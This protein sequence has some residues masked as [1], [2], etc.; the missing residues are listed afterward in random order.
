MITFT[1]HDVAGAGSDLIFTAD[2]L[3]NSSIVRQGSFATFY[4]Y[5]NL[6]C[7]PA[8]IPGTRIHVF[9]PVF[10]TRESFSKQLAP[11]GI[12]L[13]YNSVHGTLEIDIPL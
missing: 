11:N 5:G 10:Y 6:A 2:S 1:V 4:M 3:D 8:L 9:G 13:I 7:N 12:D